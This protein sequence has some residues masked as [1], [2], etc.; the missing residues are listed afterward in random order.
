MKKIA[1]WE[2]NHPKTVLIAAM[3]L[4]VPALIG[5]ICTGV[6]Y[7]ILSYLPDELES[8]QGEQVLDETFNT[9]GI[10]IVITED[11]Q[12]KYTV[13]LKNEILEVN[14]VASVIWV[15]TLADIGIP[16]N[17]L[18]DDLKNVFYSADG[19]KTMMLVR[20]DP[21]GEEGSDLKAIAEIKTLLGEKAFMSG[22]SVIVDDTREI[23]DS[24]APLYIAVA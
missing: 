19:S 13:A 21:N 9:A 22:L 11:M 2:A 12:P 5:F 10:S 24:Q 20:Y 23:A 17:I 15:D 14:G 7:D 4:L 6:N 8:V 16:A 3:L 1:L 18:P